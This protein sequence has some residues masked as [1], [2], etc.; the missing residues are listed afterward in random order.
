MTSKF[1]LLWNLGSIFG[2][3]CDCLLQ[4]FGNSC[5]KLVLIGCGEL[6][7]SERI[8]WDEINSNLHLTGGED[9]GVRKERGKR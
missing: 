5:R 7:T 2:E 1:T 4:F 8:G 3:L 6:G 9:G